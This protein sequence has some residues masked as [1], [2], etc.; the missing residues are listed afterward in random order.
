MQ[1]ISNYQANIELPS[2]V[3]YLD[4]TSDVNELVKTL[5]GKEYEV[6]Y[7]CMFP[8]TGQ[9]PNGDWQEGDIEVCDNGSRYLLSYDFVETDNDKGR[10]V[11]Y[12]TELSA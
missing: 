12:W 6:V 3:L 4:R 9:S 10:I 5:L 11:R 8:S 1:T 7:T 2:H